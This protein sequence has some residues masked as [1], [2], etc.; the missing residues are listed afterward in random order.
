MLHGESHRLGKG[1]SSSFYTRL[2][3]LASAFMAGML[4]FTFWAAV[5]LA[6]RYYDSNGVKSS[7]AIIVALFLGVFSLALC[8]HRWKMRQLLKKHQVDDPILGEMTSILVSATSALCILAGM[9][10]RR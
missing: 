1:F 9:F 4:G 8:A 3:S 5:H 10:L 6:R 7:N 2:A